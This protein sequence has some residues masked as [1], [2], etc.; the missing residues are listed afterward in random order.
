MYIENNPI[1]DINN[2]ANILCIEA[3]CC[4]HCCPEKAVSITY[5]EC[6]FV[7]LD[8]Q[9]AMRMLYSVFCGLPSSTTFFHIV[10][11]TARLKKLLNIKFMF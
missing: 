4:N 3:R 9:H 11:Y 1:P 2:T 8:A 6:V 5:S 10:S 7:G